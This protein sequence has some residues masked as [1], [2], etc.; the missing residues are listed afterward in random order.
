MHLSRLECRQQNVARVR[1][2]LCGDVNFAVQV[3]VPLGQDDAV[4]GLPP[5]VIGV[6]VIRAR[7]V[8]VGVLQ[9]HPSFVD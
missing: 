1:L 6:N 4:V 8:G 2:T 7:D 5:N 3:D 9:F